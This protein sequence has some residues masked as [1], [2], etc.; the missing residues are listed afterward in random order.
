MSYDVNSVVL[1]GRL[2]SDVELK[3]T[4][5]GT[6]VAKFGIAVG[7]KPTE[8][9]DNTSFFSVVVW[10]KSAENVNT[11]LK[12]GQRCALKGRIESSSWQAQD[13]TKRSKVEVVAEMVEFLEPVNKSNVAP[14]KQETLS[15]TMPGIDP[16]FIQE[17][18][19]F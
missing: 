14:T 2:T 9:K 1:V 13:G 11:Y 12:K 7:G 19:N 4:P 3:Y 16:E 18:P 10:G 8:G 6:A 15:D 5:S 17:D